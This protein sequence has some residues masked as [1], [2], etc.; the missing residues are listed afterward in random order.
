M[1]WDFYVGFG[2]VSLIIYIF[3]MVRLIAS[4]PASDN[5][6]ASVPPMGITD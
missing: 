5:G 6:V 2:D 4:F 1:L 3:R